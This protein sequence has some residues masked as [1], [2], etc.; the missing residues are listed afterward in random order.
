MQLAKDVNAMIN[1]EFNIAAE[2]VPSDQERDSTKLYNVFNLVS[3]AKRWPYINW[4]HYL[5]AFLECSW[6]CTPLVS[7]ALHGIE[8]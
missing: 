8:D 3:A 5:D 7:F 1:L 4:E 2:L 6:P